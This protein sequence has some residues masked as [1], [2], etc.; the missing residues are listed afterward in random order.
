MQYRTLSQSALEPGLDLLKSEKAMADH[1]DLWVG[2]E[3]FPPNWACAKLPPTSGTA[4][5]LTILDDKS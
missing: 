3:L 1:D 4:N 2:S 5:E